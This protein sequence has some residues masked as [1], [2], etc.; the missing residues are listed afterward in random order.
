MELKLATIK[1]E[2]CDEEFYIKTWKVGI[3]ND[4]GKLVRV[5][6]GCGREVEVK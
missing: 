5:C 3:N 4:T 2:P 1:C 6:P